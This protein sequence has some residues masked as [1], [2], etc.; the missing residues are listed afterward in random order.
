MQ[1][2][3]LI[4]TYVL[5]TDQFTHSAEIDV[6]AESP[7]MYSLKESALQLS[8]QHEAGPCPALDT[9]QPWSRMASCSD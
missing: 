8:C 2:K 9:I 1:C 4:V 3:W 5:L 7:A 6:C